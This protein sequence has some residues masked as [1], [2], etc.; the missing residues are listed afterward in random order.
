MD[1]YCVDRDPPPRRSGCVL[2]PTAMG[3]AADWQCT[4]TTVHGTEAPPSGVLHDTSYPCKGPNCSSP[5]FCASARK[6][7]TP[8]SATSS[9]CGAVRDCVNKGRRHATCL[10][11]PQTVRT[12]TGG[13]RRPSPAIP[14]LQAFAGS[15]P[16]RVSGTSAITYA[17]QLPPGRHGSIEHTWEST[18]STNS[19]LRLYM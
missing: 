9:S 7:I 15:N 3:R 12:S 10:G 6:W 4:V 1:R 13:H 5:E 2:Y 8:T 18:R 14:L 17:H 16:L 19:T 11:F